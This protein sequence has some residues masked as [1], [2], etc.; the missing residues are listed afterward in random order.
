MPRR[1]ATPPRD[2]CAECGRL[3]LPDAAARFRRRFL[4]ALPDH[5]REWVGQLLNLGYQVAETGEPV[6]VVLYALERFAQDLRDQGVA[7]PAFPR[8]TPPA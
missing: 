4:G 2:R 8:E 3:A 5:T 6:A 7:V 1:R